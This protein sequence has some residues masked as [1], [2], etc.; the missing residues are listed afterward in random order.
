VRDVER[1]SHLA[2]FFISSG[3]VHEAGKAPLF[4]LLESMTCELPVP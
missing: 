2:A 1:S 4:A 3:S